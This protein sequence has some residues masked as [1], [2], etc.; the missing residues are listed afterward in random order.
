MNRTLYIFFAAALISFC[1]GVLGALFTTTIY[2]VPIFSPTAPLFV[3]R[4][5][6]DRRSADIDRI[7]TEVNPSI[8]RLVEDVGKKFEH[9]GYGVFISSDGWIL[10]H[11]KDF[12]RQQSFRI[13][14]H[15]NVVYSITTV[16]RDEA[17]PF[18][19]V[20]IATKNAKSAELFQDSI[21][22]IP[23]HGFLIKGP[24]SIQKLLITPL[25][26]PYE[27]TANGTQK[28]DNFLKRFNYQ[29]QYS[30]IGIP[31]FSAKGEFMGF[32]AIQGILPASTVRRSVLDVFRSKKIERATI[33]VE[34]RDLA[35]ETSE[36]N[37]KKIE[38]G[39]LLV[40]SRGT[41]YHLKG[42]DGI[43]VRLLGGDSITQVNDEVLDRNRNLSEVLLAY[44]IGDHVSITVLQK[45]EKKIFEIILENSNLYK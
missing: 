20:R 3:D 4:G 8:V 22:T 34:Y 23:L 35:W 5:I 10:L 12:I 42:P 9:R 25:G 37:T 1:S 43:S 28:P 36:E 19:Y 31:V 16:V 11:Q 40:G 30:E 27:L 41:T 13:I 45:G 7:P 24:G 18:L 15:K 32:T 33:P 44:R 38:G 14:D 39:A 21:T 29:E 17:L 26:Y 2:S 6:P